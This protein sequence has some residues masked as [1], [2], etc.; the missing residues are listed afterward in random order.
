MCLANKVW[1]QVLAIVDL[2]TVLHNRGLDKAIG[3]SPKSMDKL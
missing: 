3:M 1:C 2:F